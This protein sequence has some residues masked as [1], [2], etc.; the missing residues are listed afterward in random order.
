MQEASIYEYIKI[1]ILIIDIYY[2]LWYL[3]T[4]NHVRN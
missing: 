1:D 4:N 3:T 2:L